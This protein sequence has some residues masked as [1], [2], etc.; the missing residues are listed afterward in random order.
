MRLSFCF[1]HFI[2]VSDLFVIVLIQFFINYSIAVED[3]VEP[4][5][6]SSQVEVRAVFIECMVHNRYINIFLL[7]HTG[8]VFDDKLTWYML[9]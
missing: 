8:Y 4:K 9:L 2:L 1:S 7:I 6:K 3:Y 5:E